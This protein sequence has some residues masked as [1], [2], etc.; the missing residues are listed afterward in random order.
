MAG[1]FL[2]KG[3]ATGALEEKM[4]S[5]K[6]QTRKKRR[7]TLVW[8]GVA[9]AIMV[10]VCVGG[11][12]VWSMW[13]KDQEQKQNMPVY[14]KSGISI[15]HVE[16]YDGPFW[17][18]GTDRA[19]EDV[20]QLTVLNTSDQDIQ[21]LKIV[22]KDE[23]GSSLGEFEITTLIAGSTVQVLEASAVQMPGNAQ[24][25]TYSIENLAY[26]KQERSLHTD[27]FT[28]SVADQWIRLENNSSENIE[29][30]IYI[31]YK[32]IEDNVLQGG[33][34]YRV[35]FAGGLEAGESREEQTQHFDPDTCEIMYLTYQ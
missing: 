27:K 3:E 13:G 14:L 15:E 7:N 34:T 31:Y 2:W 29:N 28:L 18:D 11:L 5:S 35:K 33:I 17:E 26:L 16:A 10:A 24:S 20:W 19:V 32:R 21:Y 30:D 23:N 22:A 6:G 12:F 1:G 8:K 25:C 4:D 9:L